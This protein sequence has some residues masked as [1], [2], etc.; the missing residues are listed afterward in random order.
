MSSEE[1]IQQLV[2]FAGVT[3]EVAKNLLD[4]YDGNLEVAL[5]DP[6]GHRRRNRNQQLLL[7]V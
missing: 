4:V 1:K 6:D 5:S 2:D 3:R 7:E